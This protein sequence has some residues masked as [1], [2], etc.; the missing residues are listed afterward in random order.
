[1]TCVVVAGAVAFGCMVATAEG[2]G[3]KAAKAPAATVEPS[4]AAADAIKAAFP[5]ATQKRVTASKDGKTFMV[6]LAEGKAEC[7]VTVTD[8][9]VIVSVASRVV[10]A[11]LPKSVADAAAAVGGTVTGGN[12]VEQ[13]AD[14]KTLAKLDKPTVTYALYIT[15][16]DGKGMMIVAED[17]KVVKP[18]EARQAKPAAEKKEKK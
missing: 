9:G 13:R 4:K 5:T 3:K 14:A 7:T 17:G 6:G 2:E 11:D 12:K 1:M 16:D 8:A 15:K 10:A 18:F